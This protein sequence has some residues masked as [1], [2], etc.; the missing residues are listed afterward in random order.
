[1]LFSRSWL[2]GLAAAFLFGLSQISAAAPTPD[3]TVDIVPRYCSTQAANIIDVL[4]ASQPNSANPGQSFSIA[5]GGSPASNTI[6]SA[7]TFNLIPA[8]ATGCQLAIEFP[9]LT[10]PNQIATGPAVTAEVWTTRPWDFSNLPT[11]SHPPILDQMVGTINIPTY[12]T[13]SVF[14]TI[15]ASNSCSPVMSFLVKYADWQTG[16]GTAHWFNTLGGK[17]GIIPIGFSM[18]YNC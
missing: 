13:T 5:R 17:Q 10:Q 2:S 8:G 9:I 18:V 6:I 4:Y 12:P 15:V 11:W 14:R 1:M 7:I 3:R 16:P